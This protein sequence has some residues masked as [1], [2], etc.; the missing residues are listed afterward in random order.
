MLHE[1]ERNRP[2]NELRRLKLAAADMRLVIEA[3]EALTS[4]RFAPA[5]RVLA[6][7]LVHCVRAL[8]Q[9]QRSW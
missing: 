5:P 1:S 8:L 4:D 6:T 7:G 2:F 9:Q 3:T